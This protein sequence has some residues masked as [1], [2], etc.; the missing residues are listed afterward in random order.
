MLHHPSP[1]AQGISVLWTSLSTFLSLSE[2]T[3]M[4]WVKCPLFSDLRVDLVLFS[5]LSFSQELES[6]V[7]Q[8]EC[9]LLS[10]SCPEKHHQ[11]VPKWAVRRHAPRQHLD[12]R[13]KGQPWLAKVLGLSTEGFCWGPDPKWMLFWL[14]SMCALPAQLYCKTYWG[15]TVNCDWLKRAS[16]R[17]TILCEQCTHV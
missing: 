2:T 13:C 5:V 16:P 6:E 8:N 10:K 4:Y 14:S 7:C 11:S 3:L 12:T 15:T 9:T 1:V 17:S